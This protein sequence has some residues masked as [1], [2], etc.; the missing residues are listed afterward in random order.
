MRRRHA[1]SGDRLGGCEGEQHDGHGGEGAE[2]PGG[3]V[4]GADC[5][6][7][8]CSAT[9]TV[10][11]WGCLRHRGDCNFNGSVPLSVI[12]GRAGVSRSIMILSLI[13]I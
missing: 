8:G 10:S 4:E 11:L 1:H 12:A 2:P 3:Q 9:L 5:G 6:D 7:P 13:H